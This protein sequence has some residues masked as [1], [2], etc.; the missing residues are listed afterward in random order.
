M[1]FHT[2][3]ITFLSFN[4]C[5]CTKCKH[6]RSC[7]FCAC[8]CWV[9][10]ETSCYV[11]FIMQ[12]AVMPLIVL[13]KYFLHTFFLFYFIFYNINSQNRN[14]ILNR[15]IIL[16]NLLQIKV[17][18]SFSFLRIMRMLHYTRNWEFKHICSYLCNALMSSHMSSVL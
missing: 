3:Y 12:L 14:R 10:Y 8:C 1:Q 16:F 7:L 9:W 5:F 11:T 13:V 18:I 6:F 2:H 15:L 4:I 17:L